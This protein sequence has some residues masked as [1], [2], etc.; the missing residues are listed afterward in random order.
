MQL[1]Y[2]HLFSFYKNSNN[3]GY[4]SMLVKSGG[5]MKISKKESFDN[6]KKIFLILIAASLLLAG[7]TATST[8][9][10]AQSSSQAETVEKAEIINDTPAEFAANM[11]GDFLLLDVRTQEEYD[12]GHIDGSVLIPVTELEARIGEI[13]EYKDV[14]VLVYCRSGNRSVTA[15]NILID[16]G[17]TQVH[18][19]LTGYNGWVA[20]QSN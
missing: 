16:N 5:Y 14:K 4:K 6:M 12:A 9:T 1:F 2:K 18:N 17:F 11:E 20:S 13:A 10:A 15:S 8:D 19:L 3:S 7:C